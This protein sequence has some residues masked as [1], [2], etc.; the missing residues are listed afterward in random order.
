MP[1]SVG[2]QELFDGGINMIARSQS[3]VYVRTRVADEDRCTIS[4]S[5]L[6]A[7]AE[8]TLRRDGIPISASRSPAILHV[9]VIALPSGPRCAVAIEVSLHAVVDATEGIW[10]QAADGTSLIIWEN[11]VDQTRRRVEEYV[12]V[13]ANAL[14]RALDAAENGR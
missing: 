4:E 3:S 14:R 13:I 6:T 10:V 5:L 2:G 7:E 9:S 1:N 12:S 11:Y 8:R